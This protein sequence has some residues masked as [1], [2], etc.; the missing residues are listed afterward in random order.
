MSDAWL[1]GICEF[2]GPEAVLPVGFQCLI[3]GWSP[4]SIAKRWQ[5]LDGE[6]EEGA[7]WCKAAELQ[8]SDLIIGVELNANSIKAIV[9]TYGMDFVHLRGANNEFLTCSEWE[10]AFKTNGLGLLA[11]R[12]ERDKLAGKKVTGTPINAQ[13]PAGQQVTNLSTQGKTTQPVQY[14]KL[15]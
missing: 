6:S 10:D 4:L 1:D 15:G 14:K 2:T 7:R 13:K 11:L 5:V 8:S 3:P 9:S 12:L